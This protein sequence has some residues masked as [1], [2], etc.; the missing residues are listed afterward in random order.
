MQLVMTKTTCKLQVT[1]LKN[2]KVR[3]PVVCDV[4]R[5]DHTAL[6]RFLAARPEWI[7]I[8]DG[9]PAQALRQQRLLSR[10]ADRL[11]G[12]SGYAAAELI[13]TNAWRSIHPDDLERLKRRTAAQT[14]STR[15]RITYR[16]RHKA[17]HWNWMETRTWTGNIIS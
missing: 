8:P 5:L 12:P 16:T 4:L 11:E 10:A 17:G 7:I 13:G 15:R 3:T 9:R 14:G 6:R 2:L 1:K